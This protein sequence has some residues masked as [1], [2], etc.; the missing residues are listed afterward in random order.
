MHAIFDR[1]KG[2]KCF[3]Q[4]D[5]ASGFHQMEIAEK[6]RYKTAFRDADG[7]LWESARAGFGLT[8]LPAAFTRRVQ[9]ALGHLPAA[10]LSVN[11]A[12]C[13]FGAASQEFLGMI[14]DDTEEDAFQ[15]LRGTL[16]SQTVLAF[17]DLEGRFELHTDASSLGVGV[18]LMQT[19]EGV[20]RA[21]A[22]ATHRFSRT[23]PRRGPTERECMGVSW[24][25]LRLIQY[26]MVLEWKAGVEHVVPDALSWLPVAGPAEVDVD[27][28][29]RDDLSSAVEGAS[30]EVLGSAL[31]GVR[32][33]DLDPAQADQT[34]DAVAHVPPPHLIQG[35]VYSNLSA[36]RVL[37]FAMCA[38]LDAEPRGLRCSGK[39]RTPS[40]RLRPIGDVQL[41]PVGETG[42]LQDEQVAGPT[43]VQAVPPTPPL[44]AL[45]PSPI[46]HSHD[47]IGEVLAARGEVP[48]SSSGPNVRG[49]SAID[50]AA[51]VLTKPSILAQRQRDDTLLGQDELQMDIVKIDLPS[52]TGNNYILLVVDRA[53][54]LPFGFP[55]ETK[56]A[57]GVARVLV[58]QCLTFGVPNTIRCD[59][60]SEFGAEVVTHLCRWLRTDIVFGAA[61]HPRGQGSVER[62]GGWLQELPAK[63]CRSWPDRWDGYVSPS[64]W[65]KRTLP[66]TALPSHMI[67]FKRLFDRKPRTTLDSLVP[68]TDET[69]TE[70]GLDNFVK[71]R[72]QNLREVRIALER[73]HELRVAARAKANA[74]IERS[75]AGVAVGRNSLVLV[76]ETE[77]RR[78]RDRR[79]RELQH[80]LYTGPSKVTDVIR[81]G[82]IV[83]VSLHGRRKRTRRVSTADVK[84]FHLS[85]PSLRL[86]I[87]DE[88]AAYAWGADVKLPS[89]AA[90]L[91]EF[92]SIADCRRSRSRTQVVWEYRGKLGS[93]AVSDWLS[94]DVMLRS[95]TPLQLD[96]FVALWHLYH[97]QQANDLPPVSVKPRAPLSRAEA[98]K[99]F[100]ID[101]TLR[102]ELD[103]GV[104][105][106]GQVFDFLQPYWRVGYSDQNWEELARRELERLS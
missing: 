34:E 37:P 29:S 49:T 95:F 73:R 15:S 4:L 59:G 88:F 9:S 62:L 103:G 46:H 36:L 72:K 43:P 16:A 71:R 33:A 25:A 70:G 65:I 61:D 104:N 23:D 12:K 41:P 69:G 87:S 22:F 96:G 35:A 32:L 30:V 24:W 60:G 86:S 1:L 84:P 28:A 102:K 50:R 31:D 89:G 85:P 54:K 57:V 76:R 40:V 2:K 98:L 68:L 39:T 80:D 82:L 99:L 8:V 56:Q 13:I 77:S 7:M 93:G 5:F 64:I 105:L 100:P 10:G 20:T 11:F 44:P 47:D 92:V 79:G 97:P 42:L 91:L 38:A 51:Q 67:P 17:P 106:Q 52:L 74:T 14:I 19:I 53:S 101:F 6:G 94:E 66:D 26:D 90:E 48:R 21:I 27:D 3:T 63:L 78:Y 83:E 18:S 55:L 81:P 45:P 75:S 58:E